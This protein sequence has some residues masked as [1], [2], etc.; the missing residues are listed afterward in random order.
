M[1]LRISTFPPSIAVTMTGQT[2]VRLLDTNLLQAQ[3]NI[4]DNGQ[5]FLDSKI[6]TQLSYPWG[7][8]SYQ[9][10]LTVYHHSFG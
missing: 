4:T 10:I 8:L 9:G 7:E 1:W 6:S 3:E 2:F 5:L